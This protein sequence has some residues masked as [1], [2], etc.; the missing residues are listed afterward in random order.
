MKLA[1]DSSRYSSNALM[2]FQICD[3][4]NYKYLGQIISFE[5][6][7]NHEI[8]VRIGNGWRAFWR[9][10]HILKSKMG[11]ST[12]IKIF[13]SCVL[14]VLTNGAQAWALTLKNKERLR[15][16]QY[17]M[18]RS[19]V[20]VKLRDKVSKRQIREMTGCKDMGYY[21]SKLKLKYAGHMA[22]KGNKKCCYKTTVW[23]PYDHER[24]RGR[25]PPTVARLHSKVN[26]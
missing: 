14:P 2:I 18:L 17:A 6:R 21:L 19:I 3:T 5:N 12:K 10:K 26:R 23:T 1:G 9:L 15:T 13:R 20:G 11:I 22:R 8:G 24:K 4:Q 25:P 16:T 7:I